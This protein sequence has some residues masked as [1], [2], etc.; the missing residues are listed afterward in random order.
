MDQGAGQNMDY[1]PWLY[2]K[3]YTFF[4]TVDND[5]HLAYSNES[6]VNV[7]VLNPLSQL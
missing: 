4:L 1:H 6:F 5:T 7:S 3:E 2:I